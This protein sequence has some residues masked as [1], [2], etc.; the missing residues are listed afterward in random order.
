MTL[1]E[2]LLK[3]VTKETE[4]P[5]YIEMKELIL[6]LS[7]EELKQLISYALELKAPPAL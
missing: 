4:D 7:N 6:S 1:K 2:K 5:S 3:D